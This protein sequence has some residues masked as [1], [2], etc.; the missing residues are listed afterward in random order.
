MSLY[1]L[2][3]PE[4]NS[5]LIGGSFFGPD[6][7][8]HLQHELDEAGHNATVFEL[9]KKTLERTRPVAELAV[10]SEFESPAVS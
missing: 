5:M 8:M 7:A 10:L 4:G 9:D 6:A 1:T 2:E 3:S